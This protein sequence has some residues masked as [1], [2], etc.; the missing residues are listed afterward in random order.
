[1][2]YRNIATVIFS[3][4]VIGVIGM[5]EA[6]AIKAHGETNI[7]THKSSFIN[8]FYSL[9][10]DPTKKQTSLFKLICLKRGDGLPN[11]QVIVGIAGI[12]K[13]V[14]EMLQGLS[15]ALTM[16]ATKQDFDNSVA[17][18]PTASEEWVTMDA[19]FIQ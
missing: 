1:M 11:N 6:E 7:I 18:H 12:G 9:S 14:D 10:R 5:S 17:I 15:I 19:N 4:P 8:M 13:G 3:H 2:L 16:G